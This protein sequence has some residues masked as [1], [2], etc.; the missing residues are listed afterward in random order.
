MTELILIALKPSFVFSAMTFHKDAFSLYKNKNKIYF[1]FP[2]SKRKERK[3]LFFMSLLFSNVNVF[4]QVAT[5]P[6]LHKD[7]GIQSPDPDKD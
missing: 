1:F 5:S 4:Y 7:L 2:N 3:F 6:N